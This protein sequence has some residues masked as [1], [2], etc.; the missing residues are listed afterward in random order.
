MKKI[1]I[2]ILIFTSLFLAGCNNSKK[3]IEAEQARIKAQE[4]AE[5]Q[6]KLALEAEIKRKKEEAVSNFINQYSLPELI[7]QLFIENINGNTDFVPVEKI[8][9][10]AQDEN[11]LSIIP[12]GFLFFSYNLAD[13]VEETIKFT[14]SIKTFCLGNQYIPPFLAID[15]EG[16][17]VNRLKTL[18]GPLPSEERVSSKL[19]ENQAFELYSLQAKQMNLLGLNMNLAPVVE[20]CNDLNKDF[21]NQRS[22]GDKE[23]VIKYGKACIKAYEDNKISTVLKHFPGNTNTDPHSGLPE[24]NL[25]EY[26]LMEMIS[27][28]KELIKENPAGILMSHAKTS[29]IDGN[30]PSCLSSIW[31]TKILRNDFNYNGIIFSDDIFMAALA[32]NGYSPE[33]AVELAI[34]AGI[35]CIMISE[36]RIKSPC[37]IILEKCNND[38]NFKAK[39]YEAIRH[40]IQYKINSG[41]LCLNENEDSS[42]SVSIS[43]FDS[44]ISERIK[45]FQEYKG[46]NIALYQKYF[47]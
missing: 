20:I 36:K 39:V 32:K 5:Y 17:F 2:L 45:D 40:I 11:D 9:E 30:T 34:E 22:F 19:D 10:F 4:E 46:Q 13:T 28:F 31:V 18:C 33:K 35:D 6:A 21:L 3:K 15:Q 16:G 27:P 42:F 12:G 26:E 29:G 14:D 44:D 47:Q 38:G 25:S 41:L 43:Q 37:G 7:P 24:I 1:I 23:Q 8:S